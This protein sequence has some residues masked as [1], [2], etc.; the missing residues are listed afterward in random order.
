MSMLDRLFRRKR[1]GDSG[2]RELLVRP[3]ALLAWRAAVDSW[4]SS[5]EPGPR[6]VELGDAAAAWAD[7]LRV[8][9]T[10]RGWDGEGMGTIAD[11]VTSLGLEVVPAAL[12]RAEPLRVGRLAVALMRLLIAAPEDGSLEMPLRGIRG[13]IVLLTLEGED[14]RRAVDRWASQQRVTIPA[15]HYQFLT[16]VESAASPSTSMPSPHGDGVG[17]LFDDADATLLAEAVA[18]GDRLRTGIARII[19]ARVDRFLIEIS[20]DDE[21]ISYIQCLWESDCALHLE[22][23]HGSLLDRPTPPDDLVDLRELGWQDPD[24]DV[25]NHWQIVDVGDRS[26]AD[27]AALLVRSMGIAHRA[28][29]DLP[30]QAVISAQPPQA[31]ELLFEDDDVIHEVDLNGE[32]QRVRVVAPDVV[33]SGF[34]PVEAIASWARSVSDRPSRRGEPDEALFDEVLATLRTVASAGLELRRGE[35]AG[36]RDPELVTFEKVIALLDAIENARSLSF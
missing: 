16:Q 28:F 19:Q 32:G 20:I 17:Q 14:A 4:T 8:A 22:L 3:D 31:A 15:T 9:A 1:S 11:A 21:P 30:E 2:A 27:L 29:D 12:R 18:I 35:G 24:D 33:R 25:P 36:P 26:A 7:T 23:A 13:A 34:I 5:E 6:A 10:E